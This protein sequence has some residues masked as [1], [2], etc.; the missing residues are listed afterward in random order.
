MAESLGEA[1][2]F[3]HPLAE[4]CPPAA[5][6]TEAQVPEAHTPRHPSVKGAAHTPPIAE[7]SDAVMSR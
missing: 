7:R 4:N 3:K 2:A 5:P 1:Q 6:S